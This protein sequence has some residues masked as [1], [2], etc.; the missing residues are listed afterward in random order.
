[1]IMFKIKTEIADGNNDQ[2]LRTT[3]NKNILKKLPLPPNYID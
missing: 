3:T 1:M 2:R